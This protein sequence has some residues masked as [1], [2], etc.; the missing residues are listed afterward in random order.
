[1]NCMRQSP[2]SWKLIFTR[3]AVLRLARYTSF[4]VWPGH[5]LQMVERRP[6]SPTANRTAV[7]FFARVKMPQ[8]AKA[9]H[10]VRERISEADAD[11]APVLRRLDDQRRALRPL[12]EALLSEPTAKGSNLT[13][14]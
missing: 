11:R 6:G 1:M 5:T 12:L 13:P 14:S 9:G 8:L 7:L 4:F 2:D 10:R 3:P